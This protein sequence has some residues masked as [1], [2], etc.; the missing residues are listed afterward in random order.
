MALRSDEVAPY[1]AQL[2]PQA[3]PDFPFLLLK[4]VVT[5]YSQERVGLA[6]KKLQRLLRELQG[7]IAYCP[8]LG[9]RPSILVE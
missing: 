2:E 9:I 1:L 3:P 6:D 8:V 7:I 5:L 4:E